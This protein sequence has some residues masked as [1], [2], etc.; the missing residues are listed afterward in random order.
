[1][2]EVGRLWRAGVARWPDIQLDEARFAEMVGDTVAAATAELDAGEL[3]FACAW[4][5][6][7]A[8]AARAFDREYVP[9]LR[10]RL[11]RM[12]L[13]DSDIEEVAQRVRERL[14][15]RAPGGAATL[16]RYAGQGKLRS[17]V[18]VVGTRIALD[19][20][21]GARHER[22]DEDALLALASPS[23]PRA[24]AMRREAQAGFREA[25]EVALQALAPR[26]RTALRLHIIDGLRVDEIADFYRVHRVTV[27]RWLGTARLKILERTREVARERFG[28]SGSDFET[29]FSGSR[30]SLSLDRLLAD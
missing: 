22:S 11:G 19:S 18:V 8:A 30:L 29:A 12:G 14:L 5:D 9:P 7:I 27:S 20:I 13:S 1:M 4:S 2:E 24:E 16:L 21:R 23:D 26:E 17:F 6:G 25:F 15:R 3:Y 28:M 10:R